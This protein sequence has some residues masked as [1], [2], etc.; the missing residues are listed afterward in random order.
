MTDIRAVFYGDKMVADF[1][2]Q[3]GALLADDGLQ[4]AIV[5]SL[6]T[7]PPCRAR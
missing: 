1:A 2:L 7:D 5:I 4:T 6:F 3:T